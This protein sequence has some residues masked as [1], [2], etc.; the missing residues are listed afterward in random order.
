MCSSSKHL[1]GASVKVRK[2][3]IA[4]GGR[5]NCKG[6]DPPCI[7][8]TGWVAFVFGLGYRGQCGRVG[9][10][11]LSHRPK[12]GGSTGDG[13]AGEGGSYPPTVIAPRLLS[14]WRGF[15][16]PYL[17]PPSSG[18]GTFPPFDSVSGGTAA[19]FARWGRRDLPPASG[20]TAGSGRIVA[21]LL[22]G[23]QEPHEEESD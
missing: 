12:G 2:E 9:D 15:M 6:G 14:T 5:L 7:P 3:L 20:R 21:G 17:R 4:R 10:L 11:H 13:G 18:A 8:P 23:G 22:A 19:R 16:P 1:S